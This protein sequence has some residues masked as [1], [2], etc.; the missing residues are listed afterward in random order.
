MAAKGRIGKFV[1]GFYLALVHLVLGY[2]LIDRFAP[3]IVQL[4]RPPASVADPTGPTAAPIAN[5]IEEIPSPLPSTT[6]I[7]DTAA[8]SESPVEPGYDLLVPVVGV[9]RE[10]LM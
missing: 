7:T 3:N 8:Q 1:F 2:F 4:S 9:R 5:L 10:Q 6:P